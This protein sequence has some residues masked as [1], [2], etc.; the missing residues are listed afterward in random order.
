MRVIAVGKGGRR[1][2]RP[3]P[4]ASPLGRWGAIFTCRG[5]PVLRIERAGP[6]VTAS[7]PEELRERTEQGD[8]T[9]QGRDE[10]E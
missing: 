1:R 6:L 10:P 9:E 2:T 4:V 8:T 5:Q 7:T 3:T